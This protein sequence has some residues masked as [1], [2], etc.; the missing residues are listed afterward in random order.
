M[1]VQWPQVAFTHFFSWWTYYSFELQRLQFQSHNHLKRFSWVR[2]YT[3]MQQN[4]RFMLWCQFKTEEA[5]L[6]YASKFLILP[7]SGFSTMILSQNS[8]SFSNSSVWGGNIVTLYRTSLGELE[9]LLVL[10][11]KQSKTC[12]IYHYVRHQ[13]LDK[14]YR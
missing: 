9:T 2:D 12:F 14:A 3:D 11:S 13:S 8:S 6:H 5:Y 10:H 1:F 4:I 7:L